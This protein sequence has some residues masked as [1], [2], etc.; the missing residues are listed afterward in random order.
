MKSEDD[1]PVENS[2]L[3]LDDALK[4]KQ[5]KDEAP[6][7]KSQ[8]KRFTV[9]ASADPSRYFLCKNVLLILVLKVIRIMK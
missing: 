8:P 4:V 6:F 3:S 5:M 7:P 1:Q 9:H 2:Y